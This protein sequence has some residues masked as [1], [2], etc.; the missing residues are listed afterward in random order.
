[1]GWSTGDLL[2][3]GYG[4]DGSKLSESRA[5]TSR[6]SAGQALESDLHD[7]ILAYCRAK[8]WLAIHSRMD[9]PA[10]VQI[11][12]PD[13]AIAMGGGKTVYVE[14]KRKAGKATPAQLA[15]MAGLHKLG[16]KAAIIRSFEE[17]VLFVTT[18]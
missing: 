10:T 3:R 1:M 9:V 15:W 4:P 14:A 12:T 8:G 18:P 2:A 13:F 7:K 5:S 11:G 16:H 6:D 17:F